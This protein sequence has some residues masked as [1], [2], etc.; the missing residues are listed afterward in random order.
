MHLSSPLSYRLS[1]L[2]AA[3]RNSFSRRRI[4]QYCIFFQSVKKS[5]FF[6]LNSRKFPPCAAGIFRDFQKPGFSGGIAVAPIYRN[7]AINFRCARLRDILSPAAAGNPPCDA[8][9]FSSVGEK[10]FLFQFF[11]RLFDGALFYARYV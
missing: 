5:S 1:F 8:N 3:E 6:N 11:A 10:I 4:L 2:L 7:A 9:Y